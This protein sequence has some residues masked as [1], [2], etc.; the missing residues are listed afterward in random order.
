[1]AMEIFLTSL[2]RGDFVTRRRAAA[3]SILLLL[4]F[5]AALAW[6]ACTAHGLND[7]AGRP[8]GSDFSNVYVAGMQALH[9]HAAAPFDIM[10]QQKA[11]RA[12]FGAGTPL[13]GWHYPPFF[14]LLAA[15][16]AR[17]PY[18][19]ALIVWQLGS[20]L[21]YLAALWLL[22]RT[23]AAPQL[24][25]DRLWPLLALA[26][27][28]VF[29]NLTHG[30]NGFLTAALFAGGLALLDRR[31]LL[32]GLLFGLLVYKPQFAVVIPLVLIATGRWRVLLAAIATVGALAALV[33]MIFGADVWP[34]FAAGAHFTRR[35]VLEQGGTG[36]EKI[37]SVFAAVRLWGGPVALA[38]GAQ[39]LTAVFVIVALVRMWRAEI[40]MG[41][42][43]A[44]LC[45]AALL[46]T[47][48]SL[49]YDLML[50]A[51]ALALLAAEGAARGFAP[52]ER[53]LLAL[54]WLL[55]IAVRGVA[56]ATH[57]PLAVPALLFCFG[58]IWRR[59]EKRK[60]FMP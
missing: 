58:A 44:A 36:F 33:T 35:V 49:D 27:T 51:P 21:L 3:W 28:A 23:S 40:P 53:T 47:P 24:A 34:A 10:R 20:L 39:A 18:I 38:Y 52:Y 2:R 59:I 50:L 26:F 15:P 54:L 46:I 7:Y 32:A 19:P 42:K 37:Q 48:Y 30:H 12:L 31:P 29:V 41:Y 25:R 45:L 22:L 55:P 60:S 43:G 8:L 9:G 14:L 6:L 56:D 4:G 57:V 13:Y 1:M 16:L 5:A 11:E 17:L